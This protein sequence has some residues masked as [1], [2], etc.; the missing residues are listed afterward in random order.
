MNQS[1]CH[2]N[3]IARHYH[4]GAFLQF[5][6]T[7]YIGRTEIELRTI[8]V[9]ERSMTAAFFLRQNVAFAGELRVRRNRTR[10]CQNLA[11]F[12]FFTFRTAQQYADVVAGFAF[13]QQ[14]AEHFN[15]CTGRLL[16]RFD[17]YDF[18]FVAD[19]QNTALNT[20][21]YNRT[22]A[23][24]RE[25]VFNRHQERFVFRAFRLRNIAVYRFH[26][27]NDGIMADFRIAVFQNCQC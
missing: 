5:N 13:V 24:N 16:G 14:F 15:T 9:E 6:R 17:A 8:V 7:R 2:R 21:C 10:S 3:V 1:C 26:Q 23:G 4:L 18:D 11:A 22:A 20:A 12:Y 19:M 27:F 25:Y